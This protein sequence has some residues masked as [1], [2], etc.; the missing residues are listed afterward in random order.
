MTKVKNVEYFIPFFK[1]CRNK[2]PSGAHYFYGA[3]YSIEPTMYAF[4]E[5]IKYVDAKQ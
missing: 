1:T 5:L 4:K 2:Y 3:K